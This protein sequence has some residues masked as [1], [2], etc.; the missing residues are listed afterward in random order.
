MSFQLDF[1][2]TFARLLIALM[3]YDTLLL[4]GL[5][6]V[7]T[8][9]LVLGEAYRDG[10][11]PRLVPYALPVIQIALTGELAPQGI[12]IRIGP[13]QAEKVKLSTANINIFWYGRC[14]YIEE[15]KKIRRSKSPDVFQSPN[16]VDFTVFEQPSR[17]RLL[18]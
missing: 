3:A 17:I 13:T 11:Y 14:A 16:C 1:S 18:E 9:P 10:V 2:P 8:F 7:F 5:L 4:L 12:I 6:S 15:I